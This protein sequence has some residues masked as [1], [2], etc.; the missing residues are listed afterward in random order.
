MSP[1]G[2]QILSLQSEKWVIVIHQSVVTSDGESIQD[3]PEILHLRDTND[4]TINP[5]NCLKIT[6]YDCEALWSW[7]ITIKK[8]EPRDFIPVIW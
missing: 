6:S 3:T 5:V 1:K 2:H 4:K 8:K 7:E